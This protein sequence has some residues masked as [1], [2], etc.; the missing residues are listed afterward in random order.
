M[1]DPHL[2][3]L[4]AWAVEYVELDN[5]RTIAMHRH[6]RTGE[7]EP[8]S[9]RNAVAA[10]NRWLDRARRALRPNP[11]DVPEQLVTAT[12]VGPT[13]EH[14]AGKLSADDEGALTTAVGVDA[15]RVVVRFG[16]PVAWI[17]FEA[18]GAADF[19]VAVIKHARIAGRKTGRI[20]EVNL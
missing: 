8:A 18:Q 10:T 15:G 3:E 11:N 13:G 17:G 20:I 19:A 5:Q 2:K 14:P 4:L 7:I 16:V 12:H 9:V 6:V 1:I